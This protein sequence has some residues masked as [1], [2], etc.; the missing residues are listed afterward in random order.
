[1]TGRP[2]IPHDET[3]A[4]RSIMA[5]N[6]TDPLATGDR[7]HGDE[8]VDAVEGIHLGNQRFMQVVREADVTTAPSL[9]TRDGIILP[10]N[11]DAVRG[12]EAIAQFWEAFTELGITEA[13]PVT[14]EVIPMGDH[15]LE[16]G[17]YTL[18][19]HEDVID[20][21]KILV[22]WKIEDGVWKMHRDTWNS[23]IPLPDS[24]IE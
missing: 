22:L 11:A 16:V 5:D 23:S 10:P 19:S 24:T 13:R 12:T 6:K 1:M 4:T 3:T 18:F 2:V 15:A 20:R 14:L 8:R 21:G 7:P 9:Y 17:E